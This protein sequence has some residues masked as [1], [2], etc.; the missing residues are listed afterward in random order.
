MG[1]VNNN[2]LY[3]SVCL[4]SYISPVGLLFVVKTLPRTQPPTK[5]KKL[6]GV[7][8]EATS[9]Q[10]LSTPSLGWPY[11]RAAPTDNRQGRI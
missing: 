6:C 1:C 8:S 2:E 11:I 5:V 9:L 4:L 3:V 10:K 7:F